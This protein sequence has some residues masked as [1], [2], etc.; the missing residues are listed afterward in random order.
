MRNHRRIST[1][2]RRVFTSTRD[3]RV[4]LERADLEQLQWL[5]E[6]L[7]V[8][9]APLARDVQAQLNAMKLSWLTALPSLDQVIAEQCTRSLAEFVKRAWNVLE[10]S[11]PLIWNWHL[12]VL[13]DH[14]QGILEE[15][16]RCRTAQVAHPWP[17]LA[18]AVPPGSMK[19]RI[20]SV[21]LLPWWWLHC[22]DFRA[23]YVSGNPRAALRD[24]TFCRQL[25]ESEWYEQTFSPAWRLG[26]DS[27]D[28]HRLKDWDMAKDQNAKSLFRNTANGSRLAIGAR[29]RIV[30]ERGDLLLVDDPQDATQGKADREAVNEWWDTAA[31]SR[32][33][34]LR[35]SVRILVQQRLHEDD[36]T[37]HIFAQPNTTWQRLILPAEYDPELAALCT[38]VLGF[39]DPRTEVGELLF[40][41]RLSREVLEQERSKPGGESVYQSQYNQRP[42][43]MGG[44][45]F[46]PAWW[47][48][49]RLEHE[50]EHPDP[51]M[52]ARTVVR[53]ET[54][55]DEAM[56]VDCT[57][58]KTAGSDLVASGHWGKSGA[59]SF[60][61]DLVWER[62]GFT[63]TVDAVRAQ[64]DEAPDVT[65][66]IIEDKANGS[67]V[68]D[69][70]GKEIAG[71]IGVNPRG[72]KEERAA[73]T[74][75]QVEAGQVFLPLH[76]PWLSRYLAEHT[77]FPKGKHDDAVDQQSQM[78][79]RWKTEAKPQAVGIS[80]G[81]MP[82]TEGL[83]PPKYDDTKPAGYEDGPGWG[84][85][86]WS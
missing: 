12:D 27:G 66:V 43:P 29:A 20:F 54:F 62:M 2:E 36:L 75:R 47:R 34:D 4:S 86:Q 52:R 79:L 77:A 64:R 10:P 28:L 60:L 39:Q 37:G 19:S 51:D 31:N 7:D 57:F 11:T 61:L 53:P 80:F 26:P 69:V 55:D 30:G 68:I 15:W 40:P 42:A 23:I 5:E 82:D 63:E 59:Q 67:A 84:S 32:V 3:P 81:Q 48:F 41:T 8:D 45:I 13:C 38:D 46:N 65:A 58:K 83:R 1:M 25:I 71:V 9:E 70:L 18:V 35:L 22:P 49:W 72:S 85:T 6:L 56:S 21:C 78:L 33:N 74:S 76:A 24:S 17:S 50:A 44:L 16:Q 73:A 14:A